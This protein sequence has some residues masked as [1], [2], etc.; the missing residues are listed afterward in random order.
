MS[1]FFTSLNS[2]DIEDEEKEINFYLNAL[3]PLCRSITGNENRKTLESLK[4]IIP[5]K[6]F[7]VKSGTSAYDWV[8]PDEWNIDDAYIADN[9][10]NLLIKFSDSNLHVVSYSEPVDRIIA[11]EEL[12]NHL[13][14][15]EF[16]ENAIPYRT[17]YY[18]KDWGF[19]LTKIQFEKLKSHNGPFR[20]KIDSTLAPGSLSYGELLIPGKSK[21][22]V[23]I[24][25]YICHPSMANDS[26]SGVLLTAF[27]ARS[28]LNN[29]ERNLSY[30]VIF[31]PETIG[32][33]VY[34]SINESEMKSIDFGLVITT[35]GGQGKFGYKQS[36]DPN[37]PI[38]EMIENVFQESGIEYITYP[39]DIH[40]SDERQYSSPGFRINA[41]TICKDKY[42]EYPEYHSSLDN[43]DL[44]SAQQIQESLFI[45]RKLICRMESL[46]VYKSLNPHCE[47]MLSKHNLYP[48]VGGGQRP[49]QVGEFEIDMIL[50]LLFLC[51]GRLDIKTIAD[52]LS[53]S[54]DVLI[55][56]ADRLVDRGILE[57]TSSGCGKV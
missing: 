45:Y 17:S 18:K 33:I 40:G 28:I 32:A 47:V 31:V 54:I 48:L 23:L 15:N 57:L 19:C 25:C 35:V 44:V 6:T 14:I 46:R 55:P 26:L 22:E 2:V 9:F 41:A 50:W 36:F 30:R 34:S 5:I 24:S 4:E 49:N 13:F 16:N 8:V 29:K 52:K 51:D 3:F 53:V 56:I 10:G 38:N 11:W 42:Y 21:K 43:L 7:E 20:V 37:H 39:F 12:K 27:L 1:K